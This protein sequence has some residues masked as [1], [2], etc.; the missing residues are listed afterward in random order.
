MC[1]IPMVVIRNIYRREFMADI[2]RGESTFQLL[3]FQLG[4]VVG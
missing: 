4:P 1:I 2:V 3:R